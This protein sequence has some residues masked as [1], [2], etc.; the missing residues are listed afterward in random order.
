M[1]SY[2]ELDELQDYNFDGGPLAMARANADEAKVEKPEKIVIKPKAKD[3]NLTIQDFITM[4]MGDD[5]TE[6]N[7]LLM[8][9]VIG[10]ILLAISDS[11]RH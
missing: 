6:C 2:A 7:M 10:V 1:V 9:F 11:I 4:F 5:D 8:F 3:D